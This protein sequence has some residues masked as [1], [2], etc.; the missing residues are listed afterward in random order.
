MKTRY[1]NHI[2]L[3]QGTLDMLILQTLQ[4][5]RATDT[6]IYLENFG[7]RTGMT[8]KE[9]YVS[10]RRIAFGLAILLLAVPSIFADSV[11]STERQVTKLAEGVY[12]IRHKDPFPGWVDGNTTVIIGDK[13]V[14]VVDSCQLPSAAR[15]DID[16]IRNWTDKPVR[17]LV[18]THWHL[19]HNGGNQ[20]YMKAFP[21]L[22]IIAQT[23]TRKMMDDT[24]SYLPAQVLKDATSTQD[25]IKQRLDT[26]KWP[27]GTVATEAEKLQASERLQLI[28]HIVDQ[29]KVFVYQGPTVTFDRE[30]TVDLGN[31]EVQ[32]LHFGRGNTAGDAIVYLPKEKLLVAG[33]L[34]DHPVPYAFD[35]YPSQWIETLQCISQL[36]AGTIVPGHGEVLHDKTFLLQ[37]IGLMKFV[38]ANV[39]QQL[40]QN[41]DVSLDDVKK[42]LDLS[43]FRQ[44]M[45][46]DD[47]P[48]S[49]FFSNAIG[50]GFV[51]LAYHEAKQR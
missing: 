18:N 23:E 36:D 34:L 48:N 21:A 2:E 1:R 50:S 12:T 51:E 31:R 30:L 49:N 47:Q 38:V 19:D 3:L 29:L 4:C 44:K 13:E 41:P 28:N 33:D 16:Q 6:G 20:E 5:D 39:N 11:F 45:V 9:L 17:F 40:V 42:S 25:R 27:D 35:G 14:L 24:S 43:S 37:V 15:E 22:A 32:I 7:R 46:G 26:G 10:I 8:S